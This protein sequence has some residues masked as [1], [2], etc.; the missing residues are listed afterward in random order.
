MSRRPFEVGDVVRLRD[1]LRGSTPPCYWAATAAASGYVEQVGDIGVVTGV[2][3]E[4][5]VTSVRVAMGRVG[6]AGEPWGQEWFDLVED[7]DAQV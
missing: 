4:D 5:G 3:L 2:V 1:T 6:D 7:A